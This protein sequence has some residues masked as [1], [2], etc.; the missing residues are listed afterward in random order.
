MNGQIVSG[1]SSYIHIGLKQWYPAACMTS[2]ILSVCTPQASDLTVHSHSFAYLL[3]HRDF[4]TVYLNSKISLGYVK[5]LF[6]D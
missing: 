2:M 4:S 1:T 6:L 5:N 3:P